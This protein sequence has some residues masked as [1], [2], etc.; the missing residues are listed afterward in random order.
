MRKKN[1]EKL[2]PIREKNFVRGADYKNIEGKSCQI[3]V[4]RWCEEVLKKEGGR[5]K[6]IEFARHM[7][8]EVGARDGCAR[9][10]CEVFVEKIFQE[11]RSRIE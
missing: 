11:R 2:A 7:V 10:R 5:V 6:F 8:E 1:E 4:C 9:W 3:F